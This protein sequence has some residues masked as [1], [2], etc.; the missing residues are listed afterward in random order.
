MINVFRFRP[1]Y[2]FLVALQFLTRLPVA[3]DL[4][5]KPKDLNQALYFF[6]VVGFFLGLVSVGFLKLFTHWGLAWEL[7]CALSLVA[8][9]LI[10]GCFH[11]DGLADT[12]DGLWGGF[13]PQRRLEIMKD[14]RVGTYGATALVLF[15]LVKFLALKNTSLDKLL[16]WLPMVGMLS[17]LSSLPF[18]ALMP[19]VSLSEHHKP[20]VQGISKTK[21]FVNLFVGFV[22]VYLVVPGKLFALW[23]FGCIFLWGF[24]YALFKR[25]LGGLTGD[26]LG[27]INV[28]TEVVILVMSS[29]WA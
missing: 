2:L 10:T 7:A 8:G 24:F 28:I 26:G 3:R 25:K 22:F 13:T 21:A 12:C 29:T 20:I 18:V 19:Y 15:F 14:S 27:A 9:V 16:I 5:P 23:F 17:R 4:D 11:E 6:P 1:I